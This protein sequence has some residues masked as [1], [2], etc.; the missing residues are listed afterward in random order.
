MQG[1][2][3]SNL[4][5][6]NESDHKCDTPRQ[7]F[8]HSPYDVLPNQRNSHCL[9][10]CFVEILRE[11]N[12]AG[13]P[14]HYQSMRSAIAD[15]FDQHGGSVAFGETIWPCNE[16][17]RTNG[18]GGTAEVLAFAA[19]FTISIEVH[20]SETD[21]VQEFYC[22]GPE[23]IPEL[24]L[25][26]SCWEDFETSALVDGGHWQRINK[27]C[28]MA[29]GSEFSAKFQANAL[30]LSANWRRCVSLELVVGNDGAEGDGFVPV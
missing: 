17:I 15:Y 6:Q 9:L 28:V 24:L 20:F 3:H 13:R 22:G 12:Q 7:K 5:D 16:E 11:R 1:Q 21:E 14:D 26:T 27:K 2:A 4:S 29:A 30:L 18:I 23:S 10:N 19:M 25:H 8:E